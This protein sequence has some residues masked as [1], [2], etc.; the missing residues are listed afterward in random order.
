MGTRSR[1]Q[2][3]EDWV[4]ERQMVARRMAGDLHAVERSTDGIPGATGV[5]TRSEL[6]GTIRRIGM[7]I[8]IVAA[9]FLLSGKIA[10]A[11]M[12]ADG[13]NYDFVNA[14][15]GSCEAS[16]LF[17]IG[18]TGMCTHGPDPAPTGAAADG[19]AQPAIG[20]SSA[21][22]DCTGD[23][24]SGDRVQ[25]LY[26][27]ASNI[28][29]HYSAYLSSFRQW[30]ANTDA[31]YN[32]SA[33]ATGGSRHVRF[34]HDSNCVISVIQVVIPSG[35]DTNINNMIN[36]VVNAGYDSYSRKYMIFAD[37]D[38][39]G[40]C[41]QATVYTDDSAGSGNLSNQYYGYAAIYNSCW[42]D[43]V[44]TSHELG[45]TLGAVQVSAP[46]S[47]EYNHCR[48]FYDVMC[49]SDG[50]G[51]TFSVVCANYSVDQYLLDCNHDDYFNTN[52]AP[53]SYLATHWNVA[54]SSFLQPADPKMTFDKASSKYNGWVTATLS[55]FAPNTQITLRWSDGSV[56]AQATA[57]AAGTATARFRTPLAPLGDYGVQASNAIGQSA[58]KTLRVIPRIMLN[59]TSAAAGST[60]RVY[61]YGFSPGDKVQVLYFNTAGTS[62]VVLKTVTIA[63]NG[64]GSVVVTIPAGSPHGNHMIRGS[65]VGVSR[66][67]STTFTVT[68]ATSAEDPTA[69]PTVAATA[70]PIAS[71]VVT[72][73]PTAEATPTETT[74][75]DPLA[76]DT[77]TDVPTI[78]DPLPTDTP[79]PE[80]SP[81]G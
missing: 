22:Y 62:S 24:Q 42:D 46:H 36:A 70:S 30:A 2:D 14:T 27:R 53:G 73:S 61:Y 26:V 69:T 5:Q 59:E 3:G 81:V 38:L 1:A 48:D 6:M 75:Q 31:V 44:S 55:N 40:L 34:V 29:S 21:T 23:G 35:S 72:E 56:L 60:I 10:S 66:S 16:G 12:G 13:V 18:D 68:A 74:T 19:M 11:H 64:R 45:H 4:W 41:G 57:N 8:G 9:A 58:T 71:P 78:A 33:M 67:A 32:N 79:V 77:P 49:Y 25:V 54:N 17:S 76:T 28:T 7:L 37:V 20:P 43:S 51:G 63:S 52:P 47:T 65:V 39:P 15:P 50:S 80:A